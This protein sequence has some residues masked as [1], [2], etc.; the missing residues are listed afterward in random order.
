LSLRILDI[1]V[2]TGYALICLSLVSVMSP[3]GAGGEAARSTSGV[4]A[5][6]A[7]YQYVQTVGLVF[8]GDASPSQ[9]CLSLQQ[10][11][12]ATMLLGG[13]IAG[14]VCPGAPRAFEGESSLTF[15]LAGREDR[16]EAW[17]VEP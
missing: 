7:A 6:E 16:I 2:A 9:V 1:G 8:L 3:Y 13:V 11:G 10:H 5:N 17:V 4:H 12:N 15:I 14:Y